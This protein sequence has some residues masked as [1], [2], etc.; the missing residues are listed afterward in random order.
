MTFVE[1]L[2]E[3][4]ALYLV[5]GVPTVVAKRADQTFEEVFADEAIPVVDAVKSVTARQIRL[6]L[7]QLG[8]LDE[9]E[10]WVA[11]SADAASRVEWEYAN[12]V[13][14]SHPMWT[15]GAVALGKTDAEIDALFALSATL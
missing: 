13:L 6:G 3:N 15:V 14:R 11:G 8:L 1:L 4:S 12:T 10:A 9:V 7:L 2:S 5:D